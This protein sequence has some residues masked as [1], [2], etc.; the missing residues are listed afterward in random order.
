MKYDNLYLRKRASYDEMINNLV[1]DNPKIKYPDRYATFFRNSPFGS[2]FDGD[3]SYLNLEEQE[4]KIA[5]ERLQQEQLKKV[6]S[7]TQTT[8]QVL[9]ATN[10]H[11]KI[12]TGGIRD[13]TSRESS[14]TQTYNTSQEG[15]QTDIPPDEPAQTQFFDMTVDDDMD[16]T[17]QDIED[18]K[19][20]SEQTQDEKQRKVKKLYLSF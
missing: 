5:K 19:R 11:I 17:M 9:R 18:V 12:Q 15:T 16:D 13:D 3:N 4:N 7:E 6:A 8:A 14:G 10:K 1:L 2:V 20:K